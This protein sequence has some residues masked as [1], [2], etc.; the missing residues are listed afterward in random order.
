[1][2]ATVSNSPTHAVHLRVDRQGPILE[3]ARA[4]LPFYGL[5]LI[6]VLLVAFAPGPL[7]IV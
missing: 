6:V 7:F 5:G 2:R 1:M 3:T 4:L